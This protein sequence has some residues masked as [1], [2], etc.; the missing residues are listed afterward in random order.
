MDEQR[1][2]Q[3]MTFLLGLTIGSL[4]VMIIERPPKP[5]PVVST[6]NHQAVIQ[7]YNAGINDALRLPAS[8]RL[9]ETCLN[10]WS[11]RNM[12]ARDD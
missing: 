7:S 2:R 10:V 6:T 9:E 4:M 11:A 1:E 3:V 5:K 8:W 12:E